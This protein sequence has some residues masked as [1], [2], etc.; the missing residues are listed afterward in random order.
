M[1]AATDLLCFVPTILAL[2][3]NIEENIQFAQSVAIIRIFHT[4]THFCHSFIPRL[5]WP[6]QNNL[7]VNLQQKPPF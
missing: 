2:S 7:I 1:S 3:I 6:L 5:L 4:R